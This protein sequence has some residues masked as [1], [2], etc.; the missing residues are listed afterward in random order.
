[1]ADLC[2]VLVMPMSGRWSPDPQDYRSRFS[3]DREAAHAGYY[4][5]HLDDEGVD[6]RADR[7]GPRGR[8]PLHDSPQGKDAFLVLDL[9]HRDVLLGSSIVQVSDTEVVGERR[10]SSWADDRRLYFC[11]RFHPVKAKPG[12]GNLT[13]QIDA[14]AA[15][16]G[17]LLLRR[18]GR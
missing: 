5:V 13:D 9:E 1:M 17:P 4:R 10:S 16:P 12:Q 8:A 7:H 15:Q 3:H 11:M 18:P 6:A 14:T 2:D